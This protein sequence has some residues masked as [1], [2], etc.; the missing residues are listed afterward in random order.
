MHL[1]KVAHI[2]KKCNNSTTPN[3]REIGWNWLIKKQG[4]PHEWIGG[5]VVSV[6]GF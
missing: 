1:K 3:I 2:K 5:E 4:T 6:V